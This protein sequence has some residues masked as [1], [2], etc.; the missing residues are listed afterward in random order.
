VE[1]HVRNVA[2]GLVARGHEVAVW[3]VARDGRFRVRTVD[4]IEVWELP[5]PLP[6][7]SAAGLARFAVRMPRAA[8]LWSRAVRALRP[9]LIHVHCF[10]PNGTYARVIARLAGIPLVLSSHGETLADDA[11]VFTSSRFAAASLR[12]GLAAASHVTGCSQLALDDLGARF[13]LAPGRGTVVF[14]GIDLDEPVGAPPAGTGDRYIAAVG[15]AQRL[16]GFDLLVDAFA[17]AELPRD[18]QLVIG[19]GGPALEQLRTQ[20]ERLG[21]GDRVHLPGWLDRPAVGALRRGATVGVVPSR[22]EPFGI[23][24]LE[25]WRAGS[26]LIA[27]TRGGTVEFVRDGDDGLLVDPEDTAALAAALAGLI[28]DEERA[29]RLAAAGSARVR[30]FTWERV[31]DAYERIYRGIGE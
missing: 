11:S 26:P 23:A 31:V 5:A 7:R 22:T 14:N 9:E 25:V 8:L 4:G 10:G 13:G 17:R 12:R 21:V 16:K 18:V 30:A 3:T 20:A 2:R 6:E 1:E 29:A 27:T 15:R 28:D 24:A 19:G